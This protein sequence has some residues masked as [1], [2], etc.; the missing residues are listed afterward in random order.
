LREDE[1]FEDFIKRAR[2]N[3]KF[4]MTSV[5]NNLLETVNFNELC[6]QSVSN[7]VKSS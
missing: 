3:E 1:E 7:T 4:S 2:E 5:A 6:K